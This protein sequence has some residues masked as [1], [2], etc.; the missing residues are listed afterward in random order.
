MTVQCIGE[1]FGIDPSNTTQKDRLSIKPATL[2]SIFDVYLKTSAQASQAKLDESTH[3]SRSEPSGEAK[4]EAER[5]KQAGNQY[6][7]SKS[8][9]RAVES[10][11]QAIELDGTSPVVS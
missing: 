11:T 10:Y 5:H 8:Y 4:A 2:Q 3:A 6:M 7:S 1:A 9:D